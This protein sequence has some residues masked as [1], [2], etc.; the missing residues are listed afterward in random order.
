MKFEKSDI[1]ILENFASINSNMLFR[2]GNEIRTISPAK[3]VFAI[4]TINEGIPQQFAIFDLSNF[5]S[6]LS[7][8]EGELEFTN[9]HVVVTAAGGEL[10]YYFSNPD[11]ILAAPEKNIVI[12]KE[13]TFNLEASDIT[14]LQKIGALLSSP[15]LSI[16]CKKG[17]VELKLADRKNSAANSFKKVVGEH[18]GDFDIFVSFDT[19]KVLPRDYAVSISKKKVLHFEADGLQYW[20]SVDA[21]SKV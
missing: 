21:N 9:D 20:I 13:F 16:T 6:V 1:E 5:L 4:A 17:K 11:L 19:V 3:N 15:H 14:R 7:I 18:D 8:G 2:E 10:N 12:D